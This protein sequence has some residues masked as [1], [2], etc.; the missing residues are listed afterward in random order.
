LLFRIVEES[1]GSWIA[2]VVSSLVFGISHL[3]NPQA[4][5]I[6]ALATLAHLCIR[7]LRSRLVQR[8]S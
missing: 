4:T 7:P 5:I 8:E 2:V 1:L 6:G 3:V